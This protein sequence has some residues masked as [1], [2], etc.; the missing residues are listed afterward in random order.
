MTTDNDP[1]VFDLGA[2]AIWIAAFFDILPKVAVLL[3]V[4]WAIIR[5]LETRTVQHMLG[6]RAWI[7]DNDHDE[8]IL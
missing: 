6:K 3:S 4:V 1:H 7:K 5:V 2:A 8:N